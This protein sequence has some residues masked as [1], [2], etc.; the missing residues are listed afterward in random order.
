MKTDAV[1]SVK[2]ADTARRNAAAMSS[3]LPDETAVRSDGSWSTL[4]VTISMIWVIGASGRTPR[5]RAI[6]PATIGD[7][8][9]GPCS[10]RPAIDIGGDDLDARSGD[11]DALDADVRSRRAEHPSTSIRSVA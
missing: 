8:E 10:F 4:S 1:V 7:G 2:S 5:T 3:R 9:G 11:V 6:V